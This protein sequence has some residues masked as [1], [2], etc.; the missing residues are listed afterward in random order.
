MGK[1]SCSQK[2]RAAMLDRD[3]RDCM[4][5]S[6]SSM[7]IWDTMENEP[8][9]VRAPKNTSLNRCLDD[10]HEKRG[11]TREEALASIIESFNRRLQVAFVETKFV[12]LLHLCL[13]SIKKGSAVE[14]GLASHAIGLL[15]LTVGPG[16]EAREI[17]EESFATIS[18]AL[19]TQ[20]ETTKISLLQCLAVITFVGGRDYP[21]QK[22]K[23]MHIMWQVAHP[24]LGSD[25]ATTAKPSAEVT[26]VAVS[27]WAFLLAA[28]D[29]W[30][31]NHKSWKESISYLC[32]L[33]DSTLPMAAGEALALIFEMGS[34]EKFSCDDEDK[35]EFDGLRSHVI[36]RA[37]GVSVEAG[38]KGSTKKDR[39]SQSHT[40]G[41]ILD[42]L[43]N[44]STWETSVNTGGGSS[45]NTTTWAQRLQ[46]NFLKHFL[47]RGLA[48]HMK[49]NRFLHYVFGITP[50]Q[51]FRSD[52]EL[53]MSADEKVKPIHYQAF[54][55]SHKKKITPTEK[56]MYKS[57][58]SA[59]NKARTQ[60]LNRQRNSV[61]STNT[62]Y[63]AD[64][65]D[66]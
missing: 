6:S 66:D 41:D 26:T 39:S 19:R 8:S 60:Q 40:F 7:P 44:G 29:I 20:P 54:D 17:L 9:Q 18:D 3:D 32:T 46:L 34:L 4:A 56:R 14:V 51:K 38:N 27:A 50:K 47:G 1:R 55:F 57:P 13:N 48:M 62:G 64:G 5:S 10:L 59:L 33:L 65:A 25:V 23:S 11:S 15:A 24:N 16:E 35:G 2:K 28:M 31:V 21:E 52:E 30:A 49:E 22:E 53:R 37:R 63:F 36:A 12:T 45:L 61:E 58:N 43:E 42:F